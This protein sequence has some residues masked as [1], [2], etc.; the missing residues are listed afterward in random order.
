MKSRIA[1]VAAAMCLG[2]INP[3]V[4][5]SAGLLDKTIRISWFQQTPGTSAGGTETTNAGRSLAITIY[6]SSAGRAFAKLTSRTGQLSGGKNFGPE[7]STFR[8]DG[9]KLVGVLH[10]QNH[11]T[12][13]TV[14]FDGSFQSCTLQVILG[15]E[16]G[17]PLEWIGLNGIRYVA[18][19]HP[20]ISS[21]TC[22]VS[23]GN[24]FAN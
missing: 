16:N 9:S 22:S 23:S 21:E 20:K 24:A 11:A 3:A 1:L 4:A 18:T 8:S 17:K 13:I 7:S 15:S 12:S 6:V 2:V 10:S 5:A 14:S 19:G